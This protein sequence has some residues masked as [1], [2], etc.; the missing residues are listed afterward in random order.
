MNTTLDAINCSYCSQL[1]R[2]SA[3]TLWPR[4]MLMSCQLNLLSAKNSLFHL[5]KVR[6]KNEPHTPHTLNL[7]EII[8]R[9]KNSE[10]GKNKLELV[11]LNKMIY[12]RTERVSQGPGQSNHFLLWRSVAWNVGLSF[13]IHTWSQI[14]IAL[15]FHLNLNKPKK[16]S[17]Q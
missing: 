14:I 5:I 16:Y 10:D 12:W 7:M 17:V 9:F 4:N 15:N 1:H 13:G 3:M 11:M 8:F 2:H 6:E